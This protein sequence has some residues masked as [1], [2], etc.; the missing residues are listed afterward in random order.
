MVMIHAIVV[1]VIG[2]ICRSTGRFCRRDCTLWDLERVVFVLQ[3]AREIV[4]IEDHMC[5][6]KDRVG[7]AHEQKVALIARGSTDVSH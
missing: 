6:S 3:A 1:D 2:G 4:L 5:G 7:G